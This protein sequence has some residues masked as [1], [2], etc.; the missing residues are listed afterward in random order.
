[1]QEKDGFGNGRYIEKLINEMIMHH[2]KMNL[3]IDDKKKLITLVTEDIPEDIEK[4][5]FYSEEKVKKLG[6][7]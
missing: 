3:K 4:R 7:Q 6:F 2:S 5:L 1:M